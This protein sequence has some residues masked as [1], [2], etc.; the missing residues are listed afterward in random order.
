V[1]SF[2]ALGVSAVVFY[3]QFQEV[4]DDIHDDPSDDD[5][6]DDSTGAARDVRDMVKV[7][8]CAKI[9]ELVQY[10]VKR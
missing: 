7:S 5:N 6:H 10:Y 3:R 4:R 1:L 2:L 9:L 8:K